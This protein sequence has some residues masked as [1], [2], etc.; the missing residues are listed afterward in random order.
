LND[1]EFVGGPKVGEGTYAA[2]SARVGCGLFISPLGDGSIVKADGH[3]A[4]FEVGAGEA[5][6][7]GK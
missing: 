1:G 2:D 7:G 5:G 6:T 4:H 3:T